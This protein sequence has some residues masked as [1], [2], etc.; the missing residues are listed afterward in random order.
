M[1]YYGGKVDMLLFRVVEIFMAVPVLFLLIVAAGV[2]PKEL[3]TTYVVMVIIGCFTWTGPARFIRS[4]FFKLR[5]MD[6]VQSA[7]ATGLSLRS[8]LFKHML[9]NGVT[10][11]LVEASF[12][13]AVAILF[14]AI[15]SFL[16]LGP[17]GPG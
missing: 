5:K 10:P 9:P 7:E 17:P 3:R 15:L 11:V 13:I 16:G 14:E 4:E 2:L 8:I 6:F 12:A 1:G